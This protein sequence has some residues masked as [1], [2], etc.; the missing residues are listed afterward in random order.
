M[1][2]LVLKFLQKIRIDFTSIDRNVRSDVQ[3][4]VLT[5]GVKRLVLG[6]FTQTYYQISE[7]IRMDFKSIDRNVRSDVQKRV[8]TTGM[9]RVVLDRLTQTYYQISEKS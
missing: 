6:P 4:R 1:K 3:K 7:K 8:L 2:Q 5:T 9:K